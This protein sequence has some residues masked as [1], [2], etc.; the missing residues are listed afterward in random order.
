[1]TRIPIR[2]D[3]EFAEYERPYALIL[4]WNIAEPLKQALLKIN[5][6]TRFI[7]Q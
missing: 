4:S 5:P 6:N 1:L 3:N 7:S 2:S